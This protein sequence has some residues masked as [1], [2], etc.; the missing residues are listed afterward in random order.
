MEYMDHIRRITNELSLIQQ[1]MND[2]EIIGCV[3][4]GLDLDYDVVVNTIHITKT[5]PSF[6]ELYSM[7]LNR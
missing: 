2:R 1:P 6:E 5:P 3:L 7:F 4:D